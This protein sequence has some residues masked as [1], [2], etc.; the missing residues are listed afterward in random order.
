MRPAA[1]M[2]TRRRSVE[3]I[4]EKLYDPK[5]AAFYDLDAQNNFVRVRSM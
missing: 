3:L 4:I 1:G 5:D 2:R